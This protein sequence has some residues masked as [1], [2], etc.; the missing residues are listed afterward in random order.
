MNKSV[1][2]NVEG[3]EELTEYIAKEI[4]NISKAI[5]KPLSKYKNIEYEM[6]FIDGFFEGYEYMLRK[7]NEILEEIQKENRD[8]I[9]LG[10]VFKSNLEKIKCRMTNENEKEIKRLAREIVGIV[11]NTSGDE[12]V[13]YVENVIK[14][15]KESDENGN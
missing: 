4:R 5:E 1:K 12:A 7:I 6:I 9:M 14:R 8:K 3:N 10:A 2:N 11:Q 15:I 13:K